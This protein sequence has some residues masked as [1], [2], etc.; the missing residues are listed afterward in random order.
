[1]HETHGHQRESLMW[2][3]GTGTLQAHCTL[4]CVWITH[5]MNAR[6]ILA[7]SHIK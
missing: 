1:M 2:A 3:Q 6:P 7:C 4:P 5:K